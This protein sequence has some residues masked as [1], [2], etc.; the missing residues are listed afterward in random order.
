MA[1]APGFPNAVWYSDAAIG[2][3]VDQLHT[4]WLAFPCLS[5]LKAF[6]EFDFAGTWQR[7]LG[8]DYEPIVEA[9]KVR[10]GDAVAV[11]NFIAKP[12]PLSLDLDEIY[13]SEFHL[14]GLRMREAYGLFRGP[15]PSSGPDPLEPSHTRVFRAKLRDSGAGYEVQEGV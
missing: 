11:L 2:I 14:Q 9:K 5:E 15:E 4:L 12:T 7:A 10:R 3:L 1:A 6:G 8:L 13:E